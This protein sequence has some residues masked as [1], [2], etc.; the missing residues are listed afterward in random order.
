MAGVKRPDGH[1]FTLAEIREMSVE[2]F[3]ANEE[4]IDAQLPALGQAKAAERRAAR[5]SVGRGMYLR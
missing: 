2:D 4:A 1:A 5:V 3:A